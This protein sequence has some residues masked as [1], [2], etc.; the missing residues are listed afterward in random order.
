MPQIEI[1][2]G[3]RSFEVACQDGEE[4]FLMSAARMLDTEATA[5]SHQIGRVPEARMLLMAGLMLADKT[6]GLEERLYETERQ[7]AALS[8][9]VARLEAA[10]TETRVERVEVP[11]E[12]PVLPQE[13]LRLL[14]D[15]ARRTEA[16]AG[17][18][19]EKVSD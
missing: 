7:I 6:A 2:I 5:L 19:D 8:A 17:Q 18:I 13:V 16:L 3:G 9:H 12:V 4:P 14:D 15:I 10:E 1:M 11:V